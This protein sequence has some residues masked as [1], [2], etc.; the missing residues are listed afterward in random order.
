MS[1]LDKKLHMVVGMHVNDDGG[2]VHNI[3]VQ[4]LQIFLTEPKLFNPFYQLRLSQPVKF[5]AFFLH[6]N[7]CISLQF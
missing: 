2:I 6:V 4:I 1:V 3:V 5:L 7:H